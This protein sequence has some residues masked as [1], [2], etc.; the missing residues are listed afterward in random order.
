MP[1]KTKRPVSVHYYSPPLPAGWLGYIQDV[2]KNWIAFFDEKGKVLFFPS[3]DETGAVV[4][5][6]GIPSRVR[7]E[8]IEAKGAS[9]GE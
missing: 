3:R 5:S 1:R 7:G 4:V 8:D 9:N 2:S 6:E